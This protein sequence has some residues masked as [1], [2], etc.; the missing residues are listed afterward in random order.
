MILRVSNKNKLIASFVALL[1][2]GLLAS[3]T[4]AYFHVKSR[5]EN[6][7]QQEIQLKANVVAAK[8]NNLTKSMIEQVEHFALHLNL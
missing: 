1:L 4:V 3:T 2:I 5:L 6:A 8:I 7:I